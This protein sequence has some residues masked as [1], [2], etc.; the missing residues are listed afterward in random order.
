[1]K[2]L[3]SAIKRDR[4]VTV[5]WS[6]L[7]AGAVNSLIIIKLALWNCPINYRIASIALTVARLRK[8]EISTRTP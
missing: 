4:K 6:A 2:Q 8:P 7:I 5:V 1:M 3:D